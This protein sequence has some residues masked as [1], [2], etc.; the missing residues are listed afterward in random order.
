MF[1]QR[2]YSA[3]DRQSYGCTVATVYYEYIVHGEKYGDT[4]EKPFILHES[5]A[6]YAGQFVKGADFKIRVKL[7]EPTTSIPL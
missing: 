4:F 6:V 1:D 3:I 5:G 2:F 7:D